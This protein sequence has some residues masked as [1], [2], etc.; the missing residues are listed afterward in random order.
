MLTASEARAM[1]PTLLYSGPEEGETDGQRSK[2]SRCIVISK[3]A[4]HLGFNLTPE[5][6]L[7]EKDKQKTRRDTGYIGVFFSK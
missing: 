4:A 5:Q 6:T 1:V 7:K 3:A 2:L